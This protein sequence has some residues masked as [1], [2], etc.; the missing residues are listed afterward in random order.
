M[1]LLDLVC[2]HEPGAGSL[3]HLRPAHLRSLNSNNSNN[4]R[5]PPYSKQDEQESD[6]VGTFCNDAGAGAMNTTRSFNLPAEVP[7]Y[8]QSQREIHDALLAQHPDWVLPNGDCPTCDSYDAR[9]AKLLMQLQPTSSLGLKL[10]NTHR[11]QYEFQHPTRVTKTH[12]IQ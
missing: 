4:E 2:R 6:L 11:A 3:V 5:N 12:H 1:G 8:A 10:E 7:A 9:F